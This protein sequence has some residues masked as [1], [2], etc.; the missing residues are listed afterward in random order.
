MK[1]ELFEQNYSLHLCLGNKKIKKTKKETP[2]L[3]WEIIRTA[4]P[5][6][7]ITKW[8]SLSLHGKLAILMYP[9]QG[10]LFNKRSELVSIYKHENI[11]LLQTFN[12]NDSKKYLYSLMSSNQ[13]KWTFSYSSIRIFW[14]RGHL[15]A[16]SLKKRET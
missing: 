5:Y 11:L 13:L 14:K 10:E 4:A 2:T 1:R 16:W 8:C 3:V 6:K 15:F 7:N 12:S 9:N